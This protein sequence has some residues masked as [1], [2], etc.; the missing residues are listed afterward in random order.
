M[1]DQSDP[2]VQEDDNL[3]L[4]NCPTLLTQALH[5]IPGLMDGVVATLLT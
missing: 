2:K 5:S 1:N 3:L 4:T